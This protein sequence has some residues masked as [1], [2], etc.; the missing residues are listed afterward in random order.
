MDPTHHNSTTSSV[1]VHVTVDRIP[2]QSHEDV[3][4]VTLVAQ[5]HELIEALDRRLPHL[6]SEMEDRIGR[7]SAALRRQAMDRISMLQGEV[8][9]VAPPDSNAIATLP[10]PQQHV[11]CPLC[12]TADEAMTT[13]ALE[14]G[15]DWLCTRCGQG[16]SSIRLATVAA[17]E[18]YAA[19][20]NFGR[21]GL[22][23]RLLP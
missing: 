14:A 2:D 12:H 3:N 5:L 18:H 9:R 13:F 4:S 23:P 19:E 1:Q 17:Y 16:W 20:R 8:V 11:V 7:D 22:G 21:D 15:A 10:F 6:T